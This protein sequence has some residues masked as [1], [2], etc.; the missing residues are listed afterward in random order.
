MDSYLKTLKIVYETFDIS[1]AYI[2]HTFSEEFEK[3]FKDTLRDNMYP[4]NSEKLDIIYNECL[5]QHI[6]TKDGFRK[7]S[8]IMLTDHTLID[9][10]MLR[11]RNSLI[12]IL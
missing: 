11:D 6:C 3:Q 5:S 1:H 12:I 2:V 4:V 10:D 8:I 7:D 9:Q